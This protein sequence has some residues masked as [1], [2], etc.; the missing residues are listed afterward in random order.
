MTQTTAPISGAS[1]VPEGRPPRSD[2]LA[3]MLTGTKRTF[4]PVRR[5][6]IQKPKGTAGSRGSAL[7]KFAR[8]SAALDAY[9]LIHALASSSEPYQAAYPAGTW[10]QLARLDESA[11]FDAAKSRWS[12]VV[13]K[14]K[15]LHLVE[16]VRKGN[17][18]HYRLLHESG[19]GSEYSRPK[20]SSDGHWLR[21][22]YSYWTD[23]YDKSLQHVEKLMLMIA[24]DQTDNFALPL[25]QVTDWYGLS[26]STARRGLRGLES[27][28]L[29]SKT[30]SFVL[31]P[32]S[33]TGWAEE[34]R[35]TL[36]GPFSK[37]AVETAQKTS[38]SPVA[39]QTKGDV[40]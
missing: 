14:L 35:Y 21:L 29:I 34:F 9:L 20:N 7:A 37:E 40:T 17:E 6:F 38:R 27:K 12:K 24:L 15:D 8:D 10:V 16:S 25:N 5:E 31:A 23:E 39:F 2:L 33:P 1:S 11:T 32:R 13:A 19:D 30:S 4:V 26:E 22:P 18:M 28:D 36:Q 3:L